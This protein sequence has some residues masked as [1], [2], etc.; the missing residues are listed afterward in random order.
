MINL[1]SSPLP[2]VIFLAIALALVV[3]SRL[4][5][6]KIKQGGYDA[7]ALVSRIEESETVSSDEGITTS[8]TYYVQ[9][10]DNRGE[11]REAIL[12]NPKRGLTEKSRIRIKYVPEKPRI[13]VMLESADK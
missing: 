4:R 8:Y 3:Y 5:D 7:E 6:K 13:A 9:F 12:V 11:V 10:E 2:F 1:L